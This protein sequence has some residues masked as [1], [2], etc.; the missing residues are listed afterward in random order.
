MDSPLM[1]KLALL[2]DLMILNILTVLLSLPVITAGAAMTALYDAVWRLKHNCGNLIRDYWRSF[3]GNLKQA[4]GLWLFLLL[5]GVLLGYNMLLLIGG[6]P[7]IIFMIIPMIIG[8]VVW[9]L[10][11]ISCKY[12]LPLSR[13]KIFA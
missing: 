5:F 3:C 2:F 12:F 10:L 4:T 6:Q 11:V 13:L 9:V 7:G 8:A 1:Q